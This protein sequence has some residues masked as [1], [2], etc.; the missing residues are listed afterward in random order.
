MCGYTCG[1]C[2]VAV[3]STSKYCVRPIYNLDGMSRGAFIKRAKKGDH[4]AQ[5]GFFWCEYFEGEHYSVDF[6]NDKKNKRWIQDITVIGIKKD[7]Y[8]FIAWKKIGKKFI[9]PWSEGFNNVDYINI[10]YIGDRP[11]E[12]HLRRNYDF[13]GHN[14]T[15]LKVVWESDGERQPPGKGWV[16]IKSEED[17]GIDKRKGF[18]AR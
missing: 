9:I 15:E 13:V 3:P 5:P 4:I 18:Y 1:P 6:K 2:G 7:L 8:K 16:F 10:E 11:I 14:Y 12:M 17:I